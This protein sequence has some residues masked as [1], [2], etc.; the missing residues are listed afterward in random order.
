MIAAEMFWKLYRVIIMNDFLNQEIRFLKGVGPKRAEAFNSL[1]IKNIGDLID[2]YPRSYE[3]RSVIKKINEI[4]PGE[5]ATVYCTVSNIESRRIRKNMHILKAVIFDETGYM[6]VVWFNQ[7]YYYKKLKNGSKFWFFGKMEKKF[8]PEMT[9]PIFS[10][11]HEEFAII[12]PIYKKNSELSQSNFRKSIRTAFEDERI[13]FNEIFPDWLLDEYNLPGY[14]YSIKNI[15]F[16]I[17]NNNFYKARKR[18]VFQEFFLRQA[19]LIL[20]KNQ[21]HDPAFKGYTYN[22]FTLGEKY[23]DSLG[24]ELTKAQKRAIEEI[25]ED[26]KSQTPMH[27]L[28][29]GDVGS[30]KTA[31]AVWAIAATCGNGYQSAFMAPTEILAKQHFRNLKN[32]F[33]KLSLKVVY[34]GGDQNI[35]DKQSVKNMIKEG[36]ADVIIGTHALIQESVEFNNLGLVITDE[37]HRFGVNQRNI[38]KA[39]GESPH[40]LVLTATPIPRTLAIVLYGD[41]DISIIDEMPPGRTPVETYAVNELKRIRILEFAE[42]RMKSGSQIYYVCPRIEDD[43]DSDLVSAE[44]VYKELVS[45]FGN[46][47][48]DLIHGKMKAKEKERIMLE[49]YN[50]NID[51]LIST[52]VIEVGVDVPNAALMIIDNA[53]RFGL[54]QLHQLRGRVGRGREKSYCIMINRG[55]GNIAAKRMEIMSSSTDGFFIAEKDLAIRGPGEFFGTRQHGLPEFKIANL[56]QDIDLLKKAQEASFRLLEEDPELRLPENG[57]IMVEIEKMIRNYIPG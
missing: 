39:K 38:L 10:D 30:G 37:Q 27:R 31:V 35:K 41:L 46:F 44:S 34:L 22:N 28:V 21:Y 4:E 45:Y 54:S 42:K 29:Q 36:E 20:L 1:G 52:T 40:S 3:D 5:K 25:K 55:K 11:S 26:F 57:N 2:Y 43:D 15:H 47:K 24:F 9:N 18:L 33:E 23:T 56:Y 32:S 7:D 53:E 19:S 13:N 16:P 12:V 14:E 50:G 17:D 51:F 49:F 6:N 8:L 48:V